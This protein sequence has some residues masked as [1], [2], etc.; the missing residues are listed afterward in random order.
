MT[1]SPTTGVFVFMPAG[2]DASP[3]PF[4]LFGLNA[5][6]MLVRNTFAFV[7]AGVRRMRM[8]AD[9]SP[10]G[11]GPWYTMHRVSVRNPKAPRGKHDHQP[12]PPEKQL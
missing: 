8:A 2:E 3:S 10:V 9:P 5:L 4:S 11:P 1:Y 7:P 12:A 6:W